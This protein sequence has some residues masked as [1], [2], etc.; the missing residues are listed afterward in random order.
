ML[1]NRTHTHP[2]RFLIFLEHFPDPDSSLS[3]LHPE[4]LIRKQF[5]VFAELQKDEEFFSFQ[6][7]QKIKNDDL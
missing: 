5:K 3:T 1:L 6:M 4:V 2:T 7:L